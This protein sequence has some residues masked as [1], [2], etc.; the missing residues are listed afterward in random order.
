MGRKQY[1]PGKPRSLKEQELRKAVEQVKSSYPSKVLSKVF[2]ALLAECRSEE[3]INTAIKFQASY[4]Y[5]VATN[6][7]AITKVK[8]PLAFSN[9]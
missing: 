4:G 7:L 8:Y 6:Y 1:S 2:K 9:D 5:K 3:V